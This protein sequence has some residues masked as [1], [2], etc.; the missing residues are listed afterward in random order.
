MKRAAPYLLACALLTAQIPT[1]FA[2]TIIEQT[3]TQKMEQIFKSAGYSY[4][5]DDDG[6]LIWKLQGYRVYMIIGKDK[7]ALQ[8]RA[9]FQDTS[10]TLEHANEWNKTKN[11]S[12]TYLD[13]SG[14]PVLEL[15]L[16]LAG[17]VTEARI[18]DFL[19]TCDV[20]LQRW[21]D[22]VVQ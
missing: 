4:T 21:V 3:S 10:T 2:Q 18:L 19:K 15:D 22:E 14:D 6:D 13:D 8:F 5:V 7:N 1:A 11:Y 17:G 16:D 9:A 12:R 20:S